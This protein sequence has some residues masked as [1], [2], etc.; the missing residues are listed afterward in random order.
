MKHPFLAISVRIT[1][2]RVT[3][4]H[5]HLHAL[6]QFRIYGLLICR[7]LT[8]KMDSIYSCSRCGMDFYASGRLSN[9]KIDIF[10]NFKWT[11][12]IFIKFENERLSKRTLRVDSSEKT[13]PISYATSHISGQ[14]WD[15][16]EPKLVK[17]VR[18]PFCFF[19]IFI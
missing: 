17:P 6:H 19:E 3:V 8:I 15:R 11:L 4:L 14:Y 10:A 1:P 18:Q 5:A 12:L 7:L 13:T 9:Q 2:E 16:Y